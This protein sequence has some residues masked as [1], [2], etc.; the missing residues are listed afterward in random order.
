MSVKLVAVPSVRT[1]SGLNGPLGLAFDSAGN[2]YVS[3][4]YNDTIE[5][6]SPAGNDLGVFANT[7]AGPRHL[8]FTTDAGVPLPLANGFPVPEPATAG[9]LGAGV[10]ALAGRRRRRGSQTPVA[11]SQS[12]VEGMQSSVAAIRFPFGAMQS[13][14]AAMQSPIGRMQS[15]MGT[16]QSL[17]GAV[18]TP[19]AATQSP[20]AGMQSPIGA[21]RLPVA[22]AHFPRKSPVSSPDSLQN[23]RLLPTSATEDAAP[24]PHSAIRFPQSL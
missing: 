16:V 22:A 17:I 6:F 20:V 8:A 9:L 7:V 1:P 13:S 24:F 11:G 3:N 10:L 5:K 18:Q 2:L 19:V 12:S 4:Y 23:A 21:V 14:V 15:R